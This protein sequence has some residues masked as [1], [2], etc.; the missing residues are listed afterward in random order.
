MLL[1]HITELLE[2]RKKSVQETVKQPSHHKLQDLILAPCVANL[3]N[4][5]H[6]TLPTWPTIQIQ[7]PTTAKQ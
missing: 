5:T 1:S 2:G 7:T 6:L 3:T 4:P